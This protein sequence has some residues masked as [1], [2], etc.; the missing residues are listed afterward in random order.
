MRKTLSLIGL[1]AVLAACTP[2]QQSALMQLGPNPTLDGGSY[3]TGGGLTVAAQIVQISGMTGLCGVWS[4]SKRQA[5]FT[6][7]A[8]GRVMHSGSAY[9]DG[10]VLHRDLAFMRKVAPMTSYAGQ[11][12]KC[13][14]TQRPWSASDA[15]KQLSLRIPR[16]EV[17]REHEDGGGASIV[18]IFR[19]TGP[20]A[21]NPSLKSLLLD[22]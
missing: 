19:Q 8:A 7:G 6:K 2:A 17:H 12:A 22:N 1:S 10:E 18:A 11:S 9:L 16:Q 4:E 20:G 21:H 3:S 15:G 5:V 14:Q 13:I